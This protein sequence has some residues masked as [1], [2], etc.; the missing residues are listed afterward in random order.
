MVF[1]LCLLPWWAQLDPSL[2]SVVS[3]PP[4]VVT[5]HKLGSW[6]SKVAAQSSTSKCSRRREVGA[7]K[8]LD[9][10]ISILFFGQFNHRGHPCAR[11]GDLDTHMGGMSKNLL[12][13]N[14]PHRVS[15]SI[16]K[17]LCLM[18]SPHASQSCFPCFSGAL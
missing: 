11:G 3:G 18:G 12:P 15:L 7:V 1:L 6:T 5:G 16:A 4:C 9:L 14:P 8:G 2:V 13:L 17:G 10:E